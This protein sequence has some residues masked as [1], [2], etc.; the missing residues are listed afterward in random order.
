MSQPRTPPARPGERGTFTATWLQPPP[1]VC[2]VGVPAVATLFGL[3]L[4]RVFIP[5]LTWTL[6][7]RLGLDASVLG[8]I[9]LAIF[10]AAFLSGILWRRLG[11]LRSVVVT[12][13]GLALARLL[14]QP[15]W[16]EPLVN[17]GVAAPGVAL[18]VLYLPVGLMT[19][20]NQ[21]SPEAPAHYALGIITGLMLDTTISGGL[22]TYDLAWRTEWP[23]LLLTGLLV[24]ALWTM[25]MGLGG[26]RSGQTHQPVGSLAGWSWAGVGLFLFL[27]LV[28]FQNAARLATL[29]GWPLPLASGWVLLAE[30]VGL[31]GMVRLFRAGPRPLGPVAVVSGLLLITAVVVPGYVDGYATI[32]SFLGQVALVVLFGVLVAAAAGAARP[33]RHGVVPPAAGTGMVLLV[34]LL[35]GYYVVYQVNLPYENTALETAAGT[36]LA[37]LGGLAGVSC[38]WHITL[39]VRGWL[40]PG[41]AGLLLLPMVGVLL[42]WQAPPPVTGSGLP[43]RVMS[44]NLHNGF[45]PSGRLDMEALARVI[46][47][48]NPDIVALQEV[49]RG[50]LVSGRLDMLGWLSRRLGMTC[51][52]G[53]TAGPYWGNAILSR[54]PII[55]S[56]TVELPPRDLFLPRGITSAVVDIGGGQR[57]RVIATHFHHVP[58]DSQVRLIQ[59]PVLVGYWAG[60]GMTV[61]AGDLNAEPDSAEIAVLRQAGLV[62]SGRNSNTLTFISTAPY[63]R[64]DY[65]WLSPDLRALEYYVPVTTASDHLPVVTVVGR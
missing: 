50:W 10:A 5:G 4:L 33:T 27:E 39:E 32:M 2:A 1:A 13:G 15:W 48:S 7:D 17:L 58:A 38:R 19:S 60:R 6:G 29:S 34:A 55:S 37:L 41:L 21:K 45:S 61:L 44:Y 11:P 40:I 65:V 42:A 62:D 63:Q 23:F 16:G 35:L 26:V 43:V 52:F 25:L 64:I 51:V 36:G 12:A 14:V 3:E 53:P 57:L 8:G 22:L 46:E 9:A 20:L 49:S 54:Y 47:E 28:V 30:L 24:V 31:V 59:A 18:F 56:E